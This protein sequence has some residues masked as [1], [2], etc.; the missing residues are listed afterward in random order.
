MT[1]RDTSWYRAWSGGITV[2]CGHSR[3]A[4]VIGIADRTPYAR[5]S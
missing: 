2:A 3:R 4:R 1:D 5:A